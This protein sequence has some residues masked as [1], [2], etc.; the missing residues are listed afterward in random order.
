MRISASLAE[1]LEL[2]KIRLRFSYPQYTLMQMYSIEEMALKDEKILE[3][4]ENILK[5]LENIKKKREQVKE[6]LEDL[7]DTEKHLMSNL[8]E[9]KENHSLLVEALAKEMKNQLLKPE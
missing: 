4:K 3:I 1:R 2:E 6:Q 8:N 5:E 9:I 7:E